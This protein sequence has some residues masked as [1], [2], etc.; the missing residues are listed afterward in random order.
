MMRIIILIFSVYPLFALE[1]ECSSDI[2]M[3]YLTYDNFNDEVAIEGNLKLKL[4]NELFE[5]V[6]QVE[7]LYSDYYTNRRYLL[8]NE[9]YITN[10]YNDYRFVF[11][12]TIKYWGKLEG[13]N[14]A[15][16]Y[17]QKNYLKD[18]FNKSE[19]LGSIGFNFWKYFDENSI[20]FGAKIYEQ[21]VNYP[22]KNSPY[23]P[24][25]LAYNKE[26]KLSEQR[27]TPTVYLNYNFNSIDSEN[28]I[29][30]IH[31]YDNK[32]YFIP[33]TENILSQ[34]AYI[35]NKFLFL[36]NFIYK[37]IILKSEL[38]YT[39]IVNDKNISDYTQLS[40]GIEKSF[41]I[42]DNTFGAYIEYYKYIYMQD[43]KIKN[44]DISEIYDDDVFLA[45]KTNFNDVR[46]SEVKAG[47]LYDTKHQEKVFKVQAKSRI[48]NGLIFNLEY[49]Q[50]ASSKNKIT[51]LSIIKDSTR[52]LVELSY[53]F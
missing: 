48:I 25:T 1:Y 21:D 22:S 8:L 23:S 40:F 37:D 13:F 52:V 31:G 17:N 32:R 7:Y 43:G 27:Y 33:M 26:L 16:V 4:N 24:L 35:V 30:F 53:S 5:T 47:V 9:F 42:A 14:I 2:S 51:P 46:D 3:K 38:G 19:K 29:I 20:E 45:L 41:Y 50:I 28:N 15:D 11:G 39:S 34:Y 10:D 18:P 36:S 44:V 6:M 49:L 12:K